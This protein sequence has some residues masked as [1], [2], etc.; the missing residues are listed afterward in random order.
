MGW[1][2]YWRGARA[3]GLTAPERGRLVAH[4]RRHNRYAWANEPYDLRLADGAPIERAI[5]VGFM[6]LTQA[7]EAEASRL[8]QALTALRRLIPDA[9]W[10][11]TD[12]LGLVRWDDR[13]R[14]HSLDGD[15]RPPRPIGLP[16]RRSGWTNA[17]GLVAPARPRARPLARAELI[18]DLLRPITRGTDGTPLDPELERR[19]AHA[20]RALGSPPPEASA[21]ALMTALRDSRARPSRRRRPLVEA[22]AWT[23]RAEVFATA[24]IEASRI[25]SS[26]STDAISALLAVDPRR[27]SRLTERLGVTALCATVTCHPGA[28]PFFAALLA[29]P[30]VAQRWLAARQLFLC[31]KRRELIGEHVRRPRGLRAIFGLLEQVARGGGDVAPILAWLERTFGLYGTLAD[32]RRELRGRGVAPRALTPLGRTALRRSLADVGPSR[33]R[34]ALT[35]VER[36]SFLEEERAAIA[37]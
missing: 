9:R 26:A 5:V 18:A 32:W 20:A 36:T 28:E 31:E 24:A 29:A 21:R 10:T 4:V 33:L 19:R 25:D 30:D 12:D 13:R 15:G 17:L 16:R 11:T 37:R 14:R 35:A 1:T 7:P 2:V 34:L 6:K 27:A 8:L 23:R 3:R 22:L